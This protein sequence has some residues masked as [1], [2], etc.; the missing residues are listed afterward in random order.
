MQ[1]EMIKKRYKHGFV[2]KVPTET[3]PKG[4]NEDVICR[5]SKRKNE[6]Q[7]M[8]D[9]RDKSVSPL[10][11]FKRTKLGR[12]KISTNRLPGYSLFFCSN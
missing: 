8:L 9:T 6:P 4:L 10:V 7:W 1:E 12:F 3:F 5:I 2:T 11:N